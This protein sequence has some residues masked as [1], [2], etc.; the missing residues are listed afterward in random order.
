MC[1]DSCQRFFQPPTSTITT[2][3]M[4]SQ[5]NHKSSVEVRA[6]LEELKRR[7]EEEEAEQRRKEKEEEDRLAGE[8]AEAEAAEERERLAEAE[9]LEEE[10]RKR[11]EEI[12]KVQGAAVGTGAD[13]MVVDE[14][15]A[16]ETD[17][18]KK[19]KKTKRKQKEKEKEKREE[20]RY[21]LVS[22]GNRCRTCVRDNQACR[23]NADA[24]IR[25]R[26]R[27]EAGRVTVRA[28]SGTSCERCHTFLKKP[29]EFLGTADLRE[30]VAQKKAELAEAKKG[31]APEV[32]KSAEAEERSEPVASGSKRTRAA[33]EVVM[34]PRKRAR[35]ELPELTEGQFRAQLIA[36]LG[37]VADGV[38]VVG[39]RAAEMEEIRRQMS[40]QT[41]LLH[42]LVSARE[43]EMEAYGEV[44]A[45]DWVWPGLKEPPAQDR[46]YLGLE[47]AG[48]EEE[49]GSD[50]DWEEEEDDE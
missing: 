25:W 27:V 14:E 13:P 41:T 5:N 43:G 31:K 45:Q 40:L 34:P 46:Y 7:Q 42:R 28:P 15:S 11:A 49:G 6:K 9:R 19:E 44:Q 38:E 33:V 35:V 2:T 4:S 24:I 3:P 18:E 36:L 50:E 22:G 16:E 29:C 23:I 21:E 30:K 32:K 26:E 10:E 48:S 39:K 1:F 37:R 20:D 12:A 47:G 17:E 8:L